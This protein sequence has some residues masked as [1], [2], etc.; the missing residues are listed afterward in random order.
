M[1]QAGVLF[2][3]VGVKRKR[4]GEGRIEDW[5]W[6]SEWGDLGIVCGRLGH[7]TKHFNV[8]QYRRKFKEDSEVQD[9]SFFYHSNQVCAA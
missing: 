3:L 7:T 8:G 2:E 5:V 9:A 1:Q 6:L 4:F